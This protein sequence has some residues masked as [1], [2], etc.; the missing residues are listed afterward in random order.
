MSARFGVSEGSTQVTVHHNGIAIRNGAIHSF[1]LLAG[2]STS[3]SCG[4][5]TLDCGRCVCVLVGGPGNILSTD[6]SGDGGAIISLIP[7]GL[8]ERKLF[9]I[10]E[11][12]GS[13]AKFLVVA[14]SNSFTRGTVS[15]GCRIC[16]DCLIRLSNSLG[17][18]VVRG[19]H[20]KVA[21]TSNAGYLDTRLEFMTSGIT[22]IE[23]YRKGCRRVGEVFNAIKL[24]MGRLGERTMN[25]LSLPRGLTRKR[26]VRLAGS[27]VRQ[28]FIGGWRGGD[29][30]T[31]ARVTLLSAFYVRVF[32]GFYCG[33]GVGFKGGSPGGGSDAKSLGVTDLSLHGI[34][35]GCPNN[36]MTI[37]SFGLRVGSGRFVMFI[38]PSNYNG[39]AAL[40]VI[41]NLRRVSR[42][43]V[44][45]NSHLVGSITPGSHSVTVIFRG[46]TLCPRV[47]MFS[48][49][50]FN[51][52]LHGAPGSRV[53]HHIRRTTH[54]LSVRRLLRHG[55][56]TLSNNR[57]RHITLN[58]TV[59]HRP[60]M[61][62]LSRPLSGLSTGLHTRVHARVSG[63]RRHLNAA[64]VCMARSRARTVAVTDHVMIVGDNVVRRISAPRGLC[65]CPYGLFITN[66]VNSPRVGFVSTGLLGR[67][68]SCFIRCNARSAG[69][70]TNIGFGVGLPTCGGGSG[71]LRTCINGRI[72]VNVHPRGMRGRTSLI[73]TGGSNVISTAISIARL[74]NTRACLCV[75]DRLRT[76]GTHITPAGAT[77][78]NSGVRV[79]LRASGVRLFSG[80]A[81]LAVYGWWCWGAAR[82]SSFFIHGLG[83]LVLRRG[84]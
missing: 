40:E 32:R 24:N 3:I 13:A 35:G 16:G 30:V 80:S 60:G 44:C 73:T 34:C 47:A 43:R 4:K 70:H 77:G 9:P 46:C 45:V 75:A 54:V 59:I 65:L 74:V 52:G 11:L 10:N 49:V 39:S 15:P 14:S 20:S 6:G 69:A 68:G 61:F 19:F 62:L 48:G 38:N 84:P 27:R 42:N 22:A 83:Y 71:Y 64:F 78:P 58:H 36:M 29:G 51:L 8:G 23:V 53:G 56:G 67:N 25:K 41:T 2:I 31:G 72:V 57:H 82:E 5:R 55:P 76:V 66:F 28:V 79:T 50:T 12:S 81:R 18:R 63:L 26:Y 1:K 21:L 33:V 7:S 17:R 37:A